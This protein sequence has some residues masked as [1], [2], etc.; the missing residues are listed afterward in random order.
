MMKPI[1][2]VLLLNV[3]ITIV[4]I[5]VFFVTAFLLGYGSNSSYAKATMR[6]YILFVGIHILVNIWL[7]SKIDT[8]SLNN[9]IITLVE[10]FIVYGLIAWYYNS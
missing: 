7:L 1:Y 8:L 5:I 4:I 3:V 6:L 2:K 10:L 9:V